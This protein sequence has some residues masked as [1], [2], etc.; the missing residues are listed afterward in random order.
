[1][2]RAV[3]AY[4][5][6]SLC[7]KRVIPSGPQAASDNSGIFCVSHAST[8]RY[9]LKQVSIENEVFRAWRN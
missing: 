4:C 5:P 6:A 1:M 8:S 2:V 3:A 7:V 9:P